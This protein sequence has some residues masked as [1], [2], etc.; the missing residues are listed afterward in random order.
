MQT[1]TLETRASINKE[2]RPITTSQSKFNL[3]VLI[4]II[5][6]SHTW[7]KGELYSMVLTKSPEKQILLAALH[8]GTEIISFQS[9]ESVSLQIIEGRI[10]YYTR[11]GFVILNK[12]QVMTVHEKIKYTLTSIE[13]TVFLLTVSNGILQP[14]DK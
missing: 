3:P 7:E 8:E 11:K 12:G 13:E 2:I 6:R 14:A 5:K 1:E 4:D 9:K 10:K